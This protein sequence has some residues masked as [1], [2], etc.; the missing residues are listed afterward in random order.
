MGVGVNGV[1]PDVGGQAKRQRGEDSCRRGHVEGGAAT[2]EWQA[3][4][5]AHRAVDEQRRDGGD[6][7]RQQMHPRRHR[8]QRHECLEQLPQQGVEGVA[9]R[10]GDAQ[11]VGD[12]GVLRRIAEDDRPRQ[13]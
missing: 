9:R 7:G 4:R 1:L 10:V 3:R 11:D 13:G 6:H 12:E 8:S 5:G 2:G